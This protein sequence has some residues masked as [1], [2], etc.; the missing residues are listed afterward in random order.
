MENQPQF[1]DKNERSER[2]ERIRD[3]RRRIDEALKEAEELLE[4]AQ[5]FP[6]ASPPKR[7]QK[8]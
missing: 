4:D 3:L 2:V 8:E 6:T 1:E 7:E 5:R